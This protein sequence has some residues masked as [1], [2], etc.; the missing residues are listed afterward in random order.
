MAIDV[1]IFVFLA[2]I[3]AVIDA[4]A[5][6][7]N[8]VDRWEIYQALAYA[9][10]LHAGINSGR[11]VADIE[12]SEIDNAIGQ[13]SD[14][15]AACWVAGYLELAKAKS[16][17]LGEIFVDVNGRRVDNSHFDRE[18]LDK[19]LSPCV[20]IA[21]RRADLQ[22]HGPKHEETLHDISPNDTGHEAGRVTG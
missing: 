17:P 6:D 18:E 13:I 19:A 3:A 9:R 7:A 2:A 8:L 5:D 12:E 14:D 21:F 4:G 20:E 22:L 16:I 11:L 10:Q 1:R 15:I